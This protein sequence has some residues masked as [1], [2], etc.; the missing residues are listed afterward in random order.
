[1]GP[2]PLLTMFQNQV[3]RQLACV[4]YSTVTIRAIG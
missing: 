2:T 4:S 1:M 3:A